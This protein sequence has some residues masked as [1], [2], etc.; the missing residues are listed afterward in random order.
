M[1]H[2]H[3]AWAE[4]NQTAIKQ[5]IQNI[6]T[7]LSPHTKLCAVV[8][9][10]GYGHGAVLIAKEAISAGAEYLAVAMASE[11]MVLRESGLTA[12]I[13]MMGY[14]PPEYGEKLIEGNFTQSIFNLKQAQALNT[15]AQIRGQS[16]KVHLKIDT[17]MG[18]LGVSPEKAANLA[19]EVAQLPNIELEGVFTHFATADMGDKT[20]ALKQFSAFEGA[21]LEIEKKGL[22]IPLKH[23]ANSAATLDLPQT[24]LDMVRCGIIIYGLWPSS[25]T[26]RPIL[27]QPAMSLKTIVTQLKN[28]PTG[29]SL[30]Y[31]ATYVT[32]SPARIATL[33]IG[34]ADGWS[35]KLSGVASIVIRGQ[36][37]PL[38]GRICMDQCLAD[39]SHI[40]G[41]AEG[42]EVLLFGPP[43][44]PV[45]E[46]ASHL[47]TINYEIVCMVGKRVPRI[48][49]T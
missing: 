10:D 6:K 44:L 48:R 41:V 35:R 34:Y 26:S 20:L 11:A 13:L 25:E 14:S 31:G 38:V 40:A 32:T 1:G 28:V 8:K 19:C 7:I 27:L 5:N 43:L 9:A 45:E 46:V 2:N 4:I 15:V 42:D 36:R 23:C 18:R 37:A 49:A 33:N 47:E 29:T 24:H 17:G 22:K 21:I 30:S 12:P 3:L 39:V 16:A